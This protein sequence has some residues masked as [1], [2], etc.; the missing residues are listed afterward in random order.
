MRHILISTQQLD[1]QS[2]QMYPVRDS[3]AAKKLID[4]IQTAIRSGSNFD[5]LCAKLSEDQGSKDKG[6]KYEKVESGRMVSEFNDFYFRQPGR[7]KRR[8]KNRIWLPLY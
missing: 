4:S 6:G 2:G 3:A 7:N 1:Q 5:S 8:D